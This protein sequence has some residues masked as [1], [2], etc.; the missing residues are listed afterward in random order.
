M[1]E[2]RKRR[3]SLDEKIQVLCQSLK[4]HGKGM[5]LTREELND[6]ITRALGIW[7]S[8]QLAA[9]RRALNATGWVIEWGGHY[10]W[11]SRARVL[12]EQEVEGNAGA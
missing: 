7:R 1:M 2:A 5:R 11:G 8:D 10:E 12:F 6:E 3:M 9:F 4:K